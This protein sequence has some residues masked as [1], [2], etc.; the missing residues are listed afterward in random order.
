MERYIPGRFSERVTNVAKNVTNWW[1][2]PKPFESTGLYE[3]LGVR[4]YKRYVPLSSDWMRA[5]LKSPSQ[6][7]TDPKKMREYESTTRIL[8]A[9]HAA[10]IPIMS[11]LFATPTLDEIKISLIVVVN[12]LI[13]V[14]PIMLQRYNRTRFNNVITKLERRQETLGH[15]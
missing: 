8:E 13:N 9:T 5:R 11:L 7:S 4:P 1:F 6:Y 10:A 2:K 12:I 3:R 15:V 14:Y